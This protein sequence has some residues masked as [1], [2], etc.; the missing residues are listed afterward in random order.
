MDKAE[1]S[2]PQDPYGAETMHADL[3]LTS[4]KLLEILEKS[5]KKTMQWL[6]TE[7]RTTN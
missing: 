4:D 1:M 6:I 3:E 7:K 5:I 2:P